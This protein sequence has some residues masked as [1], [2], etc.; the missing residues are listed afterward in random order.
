MNAEEKYLQSLN[1]E[2]RIIYQDK[3]K[4]VDGELPDP[5]RLA[6]WHQD[7]TKTPPVKIN[8]ISNYILYKPS[9]YTK[10]S[11]QN[12]KSLG[13]SLEFYNAGHVHDVFM[14]DIKEGSDFCF[15]KTEV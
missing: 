14:H 7:M 12:F 4:I 15:I 1:K 11:V 9:V 5:Y 2:N 6:S 10:D 3:L 8:D 13:A